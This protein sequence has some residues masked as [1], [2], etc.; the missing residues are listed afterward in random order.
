MAHATKLEFDI[1]RKKEIKVRCKWHKIGPLW[2]WF[3]SKVSKSKDYC[4]TP[5]SLFFLLKKK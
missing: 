5:L 4:T 3:I 1:Q 2:C